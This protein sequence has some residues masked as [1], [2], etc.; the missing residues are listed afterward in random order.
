MDRFADDDFALARRLIRRRDRAALATSL[1]GAPYNSL[2]LVATDLDATPLLLLSDLARHSRNLA[3]DPRLS[4]LLDGTEGEPE[5]LAG[6][7]LSLLGQIEASRDPRLLARFVARHPASAAYAGFADFRLYRVSVAR[8][9][10]VAGFGRIA[11]L[12]GGDLRCHADLAALAAAEPELLAEF[13]ATSAAA[14]GRS[15]PAAAGS[16]Q[17]AWRATGLDPDGIDLRN[18]DRTTRL[19]F[20]APVLTARAARAALARLARAASK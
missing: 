4:L 1:G 14:L 19:D 5:P 13:N 17:S 20:A 12:D 2:V 18:K 6:P 3:C 11:W 16:D 8:A 7:R 10:L 9:H 15:L